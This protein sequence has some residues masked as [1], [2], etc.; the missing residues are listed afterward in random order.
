MQTVCPLGLC[1]VEEECPEAPCID[2]M[3]RL[4]DH[5]VEEIK[6]VSRQAEAAKRKGML[7]VSD[8]LG[9]LLR[10]LG[11]VMVDRGVVGA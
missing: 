1:R 2:C 10:T 3:R 6:I 4:G 5:M 9:A 8:D 7:D 11:L